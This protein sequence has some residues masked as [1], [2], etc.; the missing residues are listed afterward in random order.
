MYEDETDVELASIEIAKE[1]TDAWFKRMLASV[2]ANP[3]DHFYWKIVHGRLYSYR[4]NPMI[5]DLMEDEDA[6]KLVLPAEKRESA[7]LEVM[8]S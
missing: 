8:Q 7:L 1:T 4:P 6:W 3:I 5:E 2:A